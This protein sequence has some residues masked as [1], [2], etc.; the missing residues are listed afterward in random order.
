MSS[1][2]AVPPPQRGFTA[3][4]LLRS[5]AAGTAED[6]DRGGLRLKKSKLAKRQLRMKGEEMDLMRRCALQC[7]AKAA[8]PGKV[9]KDLLAIATGER[10]TRSLTCP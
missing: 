10:R 7:W 8:V 5:C 2:T 4:A 1:P 3:P 6:G 9:R